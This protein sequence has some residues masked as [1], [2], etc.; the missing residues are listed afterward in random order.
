M[1]KP[2]RADRGWLCRALHLSSQGSA[3]DGD[4]IPLLLA[5]GTTLI[6]FPAQS[7]ITY[8]A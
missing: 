6:P 4:M 7:M 8:G 3:G 5:A 1:L 2:S